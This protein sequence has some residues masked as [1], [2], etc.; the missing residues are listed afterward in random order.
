MCA[1]DTLLRTQHNPNY[2]NL[3]APVVEQTPI[4]ECS[5]AIGVTMYSNFIQMHGHINKLYTL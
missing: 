3:N 1:L 5:P 2:V 4:H